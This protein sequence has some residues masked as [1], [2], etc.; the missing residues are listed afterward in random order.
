[1][2]PPKTRI[3]TNLSCLLIF[4]SLSSFSALCLASASFRSF[5]SW[6]ILSEAIGLK[7]NASE[8]CFCLAFLKETPFQLKV[9]RCFSEHLASPGSLRQVNRKSGKPGQ[10]ISSF[11]HCSLLGIN[12][13]GEGGLVHDLREIGWILQ[14]VYII[15]L[16]ITLAPCWS[17]SQAPK[18]HPHNWGWSS[19]QEPLPHCKCLEM[20][21]S[22]WAQQSEWRL[23][24]VNSG[25]LEAF[26]S[27]KWWKYP[28]HS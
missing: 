1:M 3:L 6:S 18:W 5:S 26:F 23:I 24:I 8:F 2:K 21:I 11:S 10:Q 7:E 28:F 20:N 9:V 16:L 19:D 15:H 14:I 17:K 27:V 4:A 12:F 25:F 13:S 22:C